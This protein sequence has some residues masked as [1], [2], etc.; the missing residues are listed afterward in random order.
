MKWIICF[1]F[2][3]SRFVII[4][5]FTLSSSYSC[6]L[7]SFHIFLFTCFI[8]LHFVGIFPSYFFTFFNIFLYNYWRIWMCV[9]HKNA[10]QCSTHIRLIISCLFRHAKSIQ[11]QSEEL[12]LHKSQTKLLISF[13]L[14]NQNNNVHRSSCVRF[15][16][17]SAP[18]AIEAFWL[19]TSYCFIIVHM[20]P[21]LRSSLFSVFNSVL[22]WC[23][24]RNIRRT[25]VNNNEAQ[26]V[27]MSECSV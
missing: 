7:L 13:V 5:F 25:F 8:Q 14:N 1:F 3:T 27:L 9:G 16:F 12:K 20:F 10:S 19:F 23:I 11:I 26:Q 15:H 17:S 24:R 2:L 6:F 22:A 21:Y 18:H 4:F